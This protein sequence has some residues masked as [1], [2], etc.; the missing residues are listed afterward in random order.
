MMANTKMPRL[1]LA[2]AS[3]TYI[4]EKCMQSIV[5][6]H[7]LRSRE[8]CKRITALV[9]TQTKV[10]KLSEDA[11]LK[12]SDDE[13]R[14]AV[15][16]RISKCFN[17][18]EVDLTFVSPYNLASNWIGFME[19]LLDISPAIHR[20]KTYEQS[21]WMYSST[22]GHKLFSKYTPNIDL[23]LD[24]VLEIIRLALLMYH[25]PT[26]SIFGAPAITDL[27]DYSC[28]ITIH[29]IIREED[30][31]EACFFYSNYFNRIVS[32]RQ[33]EHY[34]WMIFEIRSVNPV[35]PYDMS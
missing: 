35:F 2:T 18:Y 8:I 27:D 7:G 12:L 32:L 16:N 23:S 1:E 26:L 22:I 25:Q 28:N 33:L 24:N 6:F 13:V 15:K 20:I 3:M 17:L 34:G 9:D 5:A 14:N 4:G 11:L 10:I 30:K 29:S 19:E 31:T 21:N